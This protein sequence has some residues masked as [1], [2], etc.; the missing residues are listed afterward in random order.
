MM[1]ILAGAVS[2][3]ALW[4]PADI[5][6]ALWLD[7]ADSGTVTLVSS[8]VSQWN[9][10]SG[11]GLNFAQSTPGKRPATSTLNSLNVIDFDGSDDVLTRG[12]N[13]IG[14]NVSSLSFFWVMRP[15]SINS[16]R[17]FFNSSHGTGNTNARVLQGFNSSSVWRIGGR[18]EDAGSFAENV[19]V[20]AT[21][22]K[23]AWRIVGFQYNYAA[24][25]LTIFRDGTQASTGA[26][27]DAGTS[28]DTNSQVA[29]LGSAV[30]G[31]TSF[32]DGQMAE[33]V[34]VHSDV[35][36]ATRQN[37]EGYLAHKWG[38]TASLPSD[39]PYKNVPPG[40]VPVRRR[41]SRSGGGVL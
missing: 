10:K 20:S 15:E 13:S 14:R 6:T 33:V 1:A 11:L 28:E 31:N 18:R 29:W 19:S 4:T 41:R 24:A 39:H 36:T 32:Y 2:D 25:S 9:D 38:L 12:S 26:F 35:T 16:D 8:A 3:M 30:V 23:D 27:L 40:F 5:T 37:I 7:A 34:A 21:S 22:D 17:R